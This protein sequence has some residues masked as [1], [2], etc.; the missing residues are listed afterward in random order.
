MK[1][2]LIEI[3]HSRFDATNGG[4]TAT[5]QEAIL[6]GPGIPGLFEAGEDRPAL[7]LVERV[8]FGEVYRHLEPVE[9]GQYMFGGNI[10]YSSDSRFPSRYP[11]KVH[12]R[13]EIKR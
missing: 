9:P 1:G 13:K 12:D 3:Y 8:L 10:A 6:V 7:R 2:L 5:A 11:L 4:V